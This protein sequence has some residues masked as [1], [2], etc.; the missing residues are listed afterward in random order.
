MLHAT[1]AL[2]V[3]AEVADGPARALLDRRLAQIA[4]DLAGNAVFRPGELPDTHF[5]RFVI[6]D[7]PRGELPALL[8]WESNHDGRADD[9]LAEIARGVP[10]IERVFE[11]CA[12]YRPGMIAAVEDWVA[13]MKQRTYPAGAFYTS[14][15]GMSRSRILNDHEVHQAIRSVLDQPPRLALGGLPPAEIQR[16]I[17]DQVKRDLR[18]DCRATLDVEPKLRLAALAGIVAVLGAA[19]LALLVLP[20][21][22]GGGWIALP[23]A[24]IVLGAAGYGALRRRECRDLATSY[25]RPVEVA[26]AVRAAE[27]Q[28]TQNQL[29]HIVDIKPGVFRLALLWLVLR[30]IDLLARLYFVHGELGGINAIHFARW[31]IL[32]DTRT[33]VTRRH[34]LLFFSN[35]DG[36]WE[37]YLGEFID[38]AASGLTAVWSNTRGFPATENLLGLGARDEEA[39]KQWTREHQIATQ[40]WWSGVP[41]STVQNILDDLWI[42]SRLDRGLA[43]HELATWLRKL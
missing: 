9:Y 26:P 19:V 37:S 30:G 1:Q 2:T 28:V 6:I 29:T 11:C 16:Q 25:V 17:C 3:L 42:R 12:G 21:I 27:D 20:W 18:L 4:C 15:R 22:A 43:D 13:W 34:R 32:R 14:Y 36:S 38:R 31:V 40:V 10:S 35:Y 24:L 39:F 23:V 5:M 41:D 33:G 7:D 8:A